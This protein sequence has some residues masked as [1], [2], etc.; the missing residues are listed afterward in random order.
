VW[1]LTQEP[2]HLFG[3][4]ELLE[5]GFGGHFLESLAWGVLEIVNMGKFDN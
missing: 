4:T 5:P 3:F 2:V 1:L